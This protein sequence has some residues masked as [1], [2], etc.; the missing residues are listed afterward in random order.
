[1]EAY[2]CT[3]ETVLRILHIPSFRGEYDKLW[4]NPQSINRTFLTKLQLVISISIRLSLDGTAANSETNT[5]AQCVHWIQSAQRWLDSPSDNAGPSIDTAQIHCLLILARTICGV[6]RESVYSSAGALLS[7]AFQLRLH[8]DPRHIYGADYAQGEIR[9]RLW[10]TI[11]EISL[12]ASMD[13]GSP[14]LLSCSDFDCSPP[15]NLDDIQ[16]HA[17]PWRGTHHVACPSNRSHRHLWPRVWR[18]LCL[19]A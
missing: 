14:P 10:F 1:M 2:F 7:T 16:I 15:A 19:F 13:S 11:A 6:D 12:Q 8:R 9:R 3:F 5:H 17:L 18:S 4:D